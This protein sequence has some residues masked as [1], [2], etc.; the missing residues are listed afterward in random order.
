MPARTGAGAERFDLAKKFLAE[1]TQDL[2]DLR[3]VPAEDE[4]SVAWDQIHESSK[5]KFYRSKIMVNVRMIEFDIVDDR[6]FGQVMHELRTFIEIRSVVLVAF[7]NEVIAAGHAKANAKVLGNA[8]DQKCRI[9]SALIRKPGPDAG[10]GGLAMRAGHHQ[11]AAPADKFLLDNFR[12]RSIEKF[13]LE[14]TFNF[15]V[16][17][18]NGV[19]DNH[20]I[21]RRL[22]VF[23]L[24]TLRHRNPQRR[25]HS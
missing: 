22:E 4:T 5:G 25:Q 11:R 9:Q 15:R 6:Q 20:A 16:A 3:A 10:R 12:E 14:R 2:A 1:R 8:A 21:G 17:A 23:R 13:S 24:V 7:D 19:A 18:W